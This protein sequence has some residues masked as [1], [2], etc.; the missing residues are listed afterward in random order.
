MIVG[1][2]ISLR[3]VREGDLDELL[4]LNS[5]I[6]ERGDYDALQ[7]PSET[8]FR[9]RFKTGYGLKTSAQC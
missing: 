9:S 8:T 3:L 2:N 6:S 7:L 5:D 1:K 4:G